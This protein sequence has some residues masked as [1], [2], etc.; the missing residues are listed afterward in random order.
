VSAKILFWYDSRT[1]SLLD[2]HAAYFGVSTIVID[3]DGRFHRGAVPPAFD[4]L[5]QAQAA[6]S[7]H[8]WVW[9]CASGS[10]LL[11]EFAHPAGDNVIYA[12]GHNVDGMGPEFDDREGDKV[13][14]RNPEVIWDYMAAYSVLY[15][16]FLL[17]HGRRA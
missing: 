16:R 7:D 14:L 6:Y 10:L 17:Q 5:D 4:T 15:D 1:Y 2:R 8:V 3:P 9:L 12:F 11:D 13:R